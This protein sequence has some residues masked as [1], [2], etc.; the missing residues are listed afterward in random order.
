MKRAPEY[1][2]PRPAA[3]HVRYPSGNLSTTATRAAAHLE[4]ATLA[5]LLPADRL[6]VIRV[7]YCPVPG[8]DTRGTRWVRTHR[9]RLAGAVTEPCPAHREPEHCEEPLDRA[10]ALAHL[11]DSHEGRVHWLRQELPL[12]TLWPEAPQPTTAEVEA[13]IASLA[14]PPWLAAGSPAHAAEVARW[15]PTV[16]RLRALA[17]A[18]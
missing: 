4:L 3:W 13:A 10:L 15:A 17:V 2:G 5:H 18:A 8:C 1:S 9:N 7:E 6:V 12:A 11:R 16:A 14:P